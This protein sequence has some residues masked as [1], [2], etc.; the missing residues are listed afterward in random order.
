VTRQLENGGYDAARDGAVPAVE[1]SVAPLTIASST[2]WVPSSTS[3]AIP[4]VIPPLMS[5]HL[6]PGSRLAAVL[7]HR[8]LCVNPVSPAL[9]SARR[10]TGIDVIIFY[11]DGGGP[12]YFRVLRKG[13][14]AAASLRPSSR[15]RSAVG[16]HDSGNDRHVP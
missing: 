13:S 14:G 3:L 4:P 16:M 1:A 10:I 2:S 6:L 7:Q 8:S 12:F 11:L 5:I 15:E 9:H